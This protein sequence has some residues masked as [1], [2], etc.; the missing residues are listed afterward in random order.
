MFRFCRPSNASQCF[1]DW[2]E[3]G[4]RL[5]DLNESVGLINLPTH[6]DSRGSLTAIEQWSDIPFEIQRIYYLHGSPSNTLRGVHAHRTLQQV[7][8]ALHGTFVASFDNGFE[9]DTYLLNSP[10]IGVLIR[11]PVWRELSE[12]S[13]DAVCLVLA[14]LPYDPHDYIYDYGTF[15]EFVDAR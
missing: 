2:H 11:G 10:T 12:F 8:I 4:T 15:L 9:K 13:S 5:Q 7:L 14:S 1:L 6:V 3:L